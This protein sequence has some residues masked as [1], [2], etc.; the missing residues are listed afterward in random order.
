[1]K[2]PMSSTIVS[3]STKNSATVFNIFLFLLVQTITKNLR[4][5]IIPISSFKSD[6][7]N[8]Q[9]CYYYSKCISVPACLNII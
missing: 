4:I 7:L 1:M 6:H 3:L 8:E 9:F 5:Y 2:T